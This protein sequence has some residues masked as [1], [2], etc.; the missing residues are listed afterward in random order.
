MN[1]VAAEIA[2][3]VGVFLQHQDLDSGARQQ[4]PQHHSSGPA[5]RDTA[6]S[7]WCRH[8][9]R[10]PPRTGSRHCLQ[11]PAGNCLLATVVITEPGSVL[12]P[13]ISAPSESITKKAW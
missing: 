13:R 5:A 6:G 11:S 12:M 9:D 4:I 7:L 8:L 10:P 2:Q 1:G 3:E